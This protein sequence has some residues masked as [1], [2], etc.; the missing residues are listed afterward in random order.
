MIALSLE[1]PEEALVEKHN[2]DG[3]GQTSGVYLFSCI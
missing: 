2:F 1:L 3:T